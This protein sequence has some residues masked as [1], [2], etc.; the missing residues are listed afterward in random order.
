MKSVL[1]NLFVLP[2]LDSVVKA[3][4]GTGA[5]TAADSTA[6]R[7]HCP[8]H[9]AHWQKLADASVRTPGPT[10]CHDITASAIGLPRGACGG[11]GLL[12]DILILRIRLGSA[13]SRPELLLLALGTFNN[14][15]TKIL[16]SDEWAAAGSPVPRDRQ[17]GVGRRRDFTSAD[18]KTHFQSY[19]KMPARR[20]AQETAWRTTAR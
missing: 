3:R 16:F 6:L 14:D 13:P 7:E 4:N 2:M 19:Y 8:H 17:A 5:P 15:G 20:R 1:P 12:L 18:R 10:Q 11:H 9:G